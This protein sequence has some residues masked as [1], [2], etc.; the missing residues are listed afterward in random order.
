MTRPQR[1]RE[2]AAMPGAVT[3]IVVVLNGIVALRR[4]VLAE[5]IASLPPSKGLFL[6]RSGAGNPPPLPG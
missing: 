4:P 2:T 1:R 5:Q 6:T 3:S